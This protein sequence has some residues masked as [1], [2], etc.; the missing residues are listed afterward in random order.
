M[1]IDLPPN[2]GDQT[3]NA[4]V[5]SDYALVILQSEP[6]ALDALDRFLETLQITQQEHN[7]RLRLAG[8]LTTMVSSRGALDAVI[9]QKARNDYEDLVFETVI[10]RK[11]RI[12][13]F[14]IEGIQDRTKVDREALEQYR[15]FVKELVERVAVKKRSI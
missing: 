2:L 8:I 5:A 14:S 3:L 1:L 12:K 7:P 4:L 13:E 9:L 11:S 15:S 6:F 10:K